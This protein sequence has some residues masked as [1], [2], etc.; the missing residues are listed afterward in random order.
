MN[1]DALRRGEPVALVADVEVALIRARDLADIYQML[2]DP[3]VNRYLF[4]EPA[5]TE[6]YEAYLMPIIEDTADAVTKG[7]WP[8]SL[9]LVL[10]RGGRFVGMAGLVANPLLPG[11]YELGFQLPKAAWGQGLA[12]HAAR[13]LVALAFEALGAHKICGDCYGGNGGSAR[14]LEKAGLRREGLQTGYYRLDEGYDD[15]VLLGLSAEDY[16]ADRAL[17]PVGS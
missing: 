15:R 4:F 10:R 7:A 13:L 16:G 8:A 14:V 11:I 12:T 6:V 2:G 1:M 5:P 9:T 17:T 3:A